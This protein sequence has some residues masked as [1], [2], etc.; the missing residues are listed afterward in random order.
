MRPIA[1]NISFTRMSSYRPTP[2]PNSS[3]STKPPIRP[4]PPIHWVLDWD[5][6]ITQHDTLS[7]LVSV[8]SST[9]PSFP[10]S[11]HWSRVTKAYLKDYNNTLSRLASNGK[12]PSTLPE[13]NKL[14]HHMRVVEERSLTRV[15]ESGIF[16]DLTWEDIHKGAGQAVRKQ[17]VSLRTGYTAFYEEFVNQDTRQIDEITILSVNWSSHFIA[18]CL[19]ASHPS[20]PVPQILSNEL[21]GLSPSIPTTPSSG[22]ILPTIISSG[23]KLQ[24]LQ[25]LRSENG[26][27]RPIVYVGD[28]WT[29]IEAI[30][31]ADLGICIRDEPMGSSQ[32][33]LAEALERLG[34]ECSRLG[35]GREREGEGGRAAWASDW[36]EIRL[37]SMIAQA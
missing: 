37:W 9:K 26:R 18:S 33:Q 24:Q 1:R 34:V 7:T 6:T 2:S 13:E 17:E 21:E 4:T 27:S 3:M 22:H 16:A 35:E 25:R 20:L 15:S 10:T 29:D 19:S 31:A 23:D 5:G 12:L 14:L 32:R 8:A 36:E 28:S 30:L 11:E